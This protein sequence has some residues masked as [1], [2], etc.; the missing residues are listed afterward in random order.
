MIMDFIHVIFFFLVGCV[1]NRW[2]LI[3][4]KK[5]RVFFFQG[6]HRLIDF[7]F[8]FEA[9]EIHVAVEVKQLIDSKQWQGPCLE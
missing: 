1:K 8:D 6:T 7:G 4:N 9:E 3:V 5:N 2:W